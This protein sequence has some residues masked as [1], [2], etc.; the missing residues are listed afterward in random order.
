MSQDETTPCAFKQL[1]EADLAFGPGKIKQSYYLVA[2][3]E[4]KIIAVL[5]AVMKRYH[6]AAVM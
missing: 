3:Q 2:V 4:L 1:G 5:V 6:K